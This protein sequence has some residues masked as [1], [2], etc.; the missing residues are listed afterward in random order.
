MSR[1]LL[2]AFP[3][4]QREKDGR[5]EGFP[6]FFLLSI[7]PL[8]QDGWRFQMSFKSRL[9][10]LLWSL[11]YVQKRLFLARNKFHF[12]LQNISSPKN[13]GERDKCT[14]P[15][16]FHIPH[17]TSAAM[18]GGVGGNLSREKCRHCGRGRR[19]PVSAGI[20]AEAT[21]L[22]TTLHGRGRWGCIAASYDSLGSRA[23]CHYFLGTSTERESERA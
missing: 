4:T 2:K 22:R 12:Q 13:V 3:G 23:I 21:V 11:F 18:A 1:C 8:S 7:L 19:V 14:G 15:L 10:L 17:T 9:P 6:I 16:I 5:E 20:T